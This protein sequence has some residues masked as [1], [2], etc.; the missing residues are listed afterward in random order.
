M[1]EAA[2]IRLLI[3]LILI[4]G[5]K[6]EIKGP[7]YDLFIEC[8]VVHQFLLGSLLPSSHY[9]LFLNSNLY[10]LSSLGSNLVF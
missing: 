7:L 1:I 8:E 2:K 6:V 10:L 3:S 4:F 9:R 5:L